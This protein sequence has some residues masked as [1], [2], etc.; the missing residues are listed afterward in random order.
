MEGLEGRK[1]KRKQCY[2]ITVTGIKEKTKNSYR[3]IKTTRETKQSSTIT[4]ILEVSYA[5]FQVIN[6][7]MVWAQ[8]QFKQIYGI[9]EMI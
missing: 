6:D 3:N 9:K 1:R 5:R 7:N 4:T 8:E 2:C